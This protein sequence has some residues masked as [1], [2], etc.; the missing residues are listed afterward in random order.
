MPRKSSKKGKPVR[1]P[2]KVTAKKPA[3]KVAARI[4]ANPSAKQG[5]RLLESEIRL[6]LALDVTQMAIWE[7]N[8][9]TNKVTW[10]NNV[11][12]IIGFRKK[13]NQ[14]TYEEYIEVVHPDDRSIVAQTVQDTI[15]NGTDLYNQHRIV[16]PD[17]S[18]QWVESR[19]KI[20]KNRKG[21][22]TKMTGTVQNITAK[23]FL[24]FDRENWKTRHELVTS[25][26][27]LVIYDYNIPTGD[28]IWSGNSE[29][30]LGYKP[31]ELGNIDRWVDLIHM[32]DRE[33]AFKLLEIAQKTLRPYDVYYRFQMRNG[34]YCYMH[35]RGFF[36]PGKDGNAVRMLGMMQ[37][38]SE[39][40]Q[41]IDQL[42]KSEQSYRE[43][44]DTVG[45]AIYFQR[46]DGVFVDVN[47]GATEMYGYDKEEFIGRTPGFLSAEG[48]NDIA[49]LQK[50]IQRAAQGE[51]QSFE[52]WG[53]KKNG[54]EFLKEV[55]L[56]KG[57]YFGQDIIIA[58]ARDITERRKAE[59]A[60]QESELR[61]RT[62]QQ[63][64]FGGI[65]LHD[66][67]TILDCNQG[68][69]D[70]TGFSYNELIGMYGIDLI[71]PEWRNVVIEKIRSNYEKPYDV[72]GIR[73]D[74]SRYFLEIHGKNIPYMGKNIRVTE[75]RDITE[76][77]RAEE[78]IIEQNTRLLALTED[79]RRKNNQLEEFTQIVSHNLRSP[80]GNIV[81]LLNFCENATSETEKSEYFTL[82]KEASTI[83]LSML[84]ELNDVLKIKQ[85][86][87][88]DKDELQFEQ[89]LLQVKAMLNAKI[90]SLS[91]D[92]R[93]DF[94][95]APVIH[96]PRI[97]LESILL[98]LL[99]NSLKYHHPDRKPV[100]TFKTCISNGNLILE[101][102]DN[103]LGINLQRYG[104]HIFKLRKTFHRHPESRGIGLFMIKNQIEAMGGEITLS[105][106]ES[107]GS[108]FFINFNKHQTDGN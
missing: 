26:A 5:K 74:G 57:T 40:R 105:S 46:L 71:A 41:A 54:E 103:G 55:R 81:T 76:R 72:E 98:N 99:S 94:S 27:G 67:G 33:E 56:T 62:L 83:T 107:E 37:D 92:I 84:N 28:I 35:D 32:D 48:R 16:W 3:K 21:E 53:R 64:S 100:V 85:N 12:R 78:E 49:D 90:T 106:K 6:N 44:F 104:H 88:I 102:S 17:G 14:Y 43:L 69:C 36:V 42:N 108:T 58:T 22:V 50:R 73:K 9:E 87:N 25:S 19:G 59:K 96:Y 97:Y 95:L 60:L 89:V 75:F 2:K 38:V 79:L 29:Q 70:I 101:T 45:E 24:E 39:Q 77:K 82:L 31:A 30:V 4:S 47:K 91:A 52:F 93:Y 51:P 68:L 15:E 10:S 20:T 7:W 61:F 34:N 8:I 80:V 86:K 1:T 63:A 11:D 65:G 13:S 66:Q 23:K 18:I